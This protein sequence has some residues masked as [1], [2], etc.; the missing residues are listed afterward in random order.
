LVTGSEHGSRIIYTATSRCLAMTNEGA[1]KWE[2]CSYLQLQDKHIPQSK[3]HA[4][5]LT[6]DKHVPAANLLQIRPSNKLGSKVKILSLSLLQVVRSF[7]IRV[8]QVA[9]VCVEHHGLRIRYTGSD[10]RCGN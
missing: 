10:Y 9:L 6:L 3:P 5:S 8:V 7:F 1:T 4:Q 2:C